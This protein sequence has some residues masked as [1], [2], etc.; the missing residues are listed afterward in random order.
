MCLNKHVTFRNV[1]AFDFDCVF[2]SP[3]VFRRL[4]FIMCIHELSTHIICSAAVISF[5]SFL[6]M[7]YY[8]LLC[9]DRMPVQ[10]TIQYADHIESTNSRAWRL[11]VCFARMEP[12]KNR[13]QNNDNAQVHSAIMA[14]LFGGNTFDVIG[15]VSM[16][17]K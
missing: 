15:F 1:L 3:M 12:V 9:S 16:A 5:Q 6:F 2:R 10:H 4:I 17:C 7:F 13:N 14:D 8:W 11:T